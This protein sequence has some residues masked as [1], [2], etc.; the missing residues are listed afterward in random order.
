MISNPP[1][2]KGLNVWIH[3]IIP[4]EG[5]GF[6]NQGSTFTCCTWTGWGEDAK[7]LLAGMTIDTDASSGAGSLRY[8]VDTK[9]LV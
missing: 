7:R 2:F 1:P 8:A 9:N 6:I 5:R 3:F 4:L